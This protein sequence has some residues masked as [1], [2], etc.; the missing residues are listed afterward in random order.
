VVTGVAL[1]GTA[2]VDGISVGDLDGDGLP[3]IAV[4]EFLGPN[5]FILKNQ[6]LPGT[7]SVVNALKLSNATAISNLRI[8]DLDGDSKPEL[9]ATALLASSVLVFGNQ[10]TSSAI[11]FATPAIISANQKP[12]GID[13][14]DMDGD[15]KTDIAVASITDKSV[16]VLSNQSTAGNFVF[17]TL[18]IPT[19]FINR[20]IRIISPVLTT[21]FWA[22]QRPRSQ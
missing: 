12:W 5:I 16:T 13:F 6:S 14:G 4:C 21:M 22:C 7:I 9:S 19:T 10:S 15:G 20:H 17:Q 1:T 8:G 11:Q 2:A 3:D 18:T